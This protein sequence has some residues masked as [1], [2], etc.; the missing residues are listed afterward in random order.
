MFKHEIFY[1]FTKRKNAKKKQRNKNISF[2][3]AII[4]LPQ[5]YVFNKLATSAHVRENAFAHICIYT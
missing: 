2:S 1:I 4:Y 3:S 5:A